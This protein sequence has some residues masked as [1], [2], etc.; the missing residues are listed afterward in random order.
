MY[1]K[2]FRIIM[3]LFH[4]KRLKIV[5]NQ[6]HRLILLISYEQK[7]QSRKRAAAIIC[8]VFFS[9]LDTFKS[10]DFMGYEDSCPV[11]VYLTMVG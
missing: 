2:D 8:T 3:V 6:N 11:V 10:C 1:E 4:G 5:T 7:K 9:Y